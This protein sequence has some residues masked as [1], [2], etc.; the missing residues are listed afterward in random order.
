MTWL[1]KRLADEMNLHDF[2]ILTAMNI[3]SAMEQNGFFSSA[4]WNGISDRDGTYRISEIVIGIFP[5]SI[6]IG[7]FKIPTHLIMDQTP[8]L[9]MLPL[10]GVFHA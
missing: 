10:D 2:S 8:M 4:K 1:L 6:R 7:T 9:P 5:C 3:T